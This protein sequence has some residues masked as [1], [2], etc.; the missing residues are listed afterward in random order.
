MNRLSE[1][2]RLSLMLLVS[3][4]LNFFLLPQMA[5][6]WLHAGHLEEFS[7]IALH[8]A[9]VKTIKLLPEK[10]PPPKLKVLPPKKIVR[11]LP[12]PRRLTPE[13]PHPQTP[14]PGK[15]KNLH[16]APNLSPH[17]LTQEPGQGSMPPSHS[18]TQ[19][20]G[21]A[22]VP[23]LPSPFPS[24]PPPSPPKPIGETRNSIA[25]YQPVPQIPESLR[26]QVLKTFV[27]A[28]FYIAP[29]GTA[30]V[31]LLTGSGSL[32]LDQLTLETLRQWRWKPALRDG[33]PVPST[34][35]LKIEFE[36]E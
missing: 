2:Q 14:H 22:G 35:Q 28:R 36:V 23:T 25:I 26:T 9:E 16:N 3:L 27:R 29:D 8:P 10:T 33:I 30:Q 17:I 4:A 6:H 24:A 15:P 11:L 12:A 7:V 5:G 18:V 32:E 20:S 1:S 19:G 13:P 34:E 31:T 21:Q